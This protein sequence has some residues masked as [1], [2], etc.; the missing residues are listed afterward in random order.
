MLGEKVPWGIFSREGISFLKDLGERVSRALSNTLLYSE[1][2]K[3]R[4]GLKW[5]YRLTVE[6][7]LRY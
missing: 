4:E 5:F 3:R 2:R 1:V 6:K 7:E